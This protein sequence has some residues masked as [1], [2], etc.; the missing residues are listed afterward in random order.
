MGKK[1]ST[2]GPETLNSLVSSAGWKNAG[3]R[4]GVFGG[5][6]G[7]AWFSIV[8][9]EIPG[10]GRYVH[11]TSVGDDCSVYLNGKKLLE[12]ERWIDAFDVPLDSA[13]KEGGPNHLVLLVENTYGPVYVG[14][15]DL[16]TVA[17]RP[18][19]PALAD[20]DDRIWRPLNLPH[21]FVVEGKFN[22]KGNDYNGYLI[23]GVGWYR[24]E[25]E[26]PASDRGRRLWLDFDGAFRNSR[27]WLNGR[28]LGRHNSGYTPFRYDITGLVRYGGRNVLSVRVDARGAEGWWYEGGGLY[29]HVWLTKADPVHVAPWGVYVVSKPVGKGAS[30]VL[31][32][33]LRSTNTNPEPG[34]LRLVNEIKDPKGRLVLRLASPLT[35]GASREKTLIQ[36]GS[37]KRALLWDLDHPHLYRVT[38]R[39]EREGRE[40]DHVE[41]S[42]G[43]RSIRF[44]KD[45]G[46]F[47][48][49]KPV[50]L[51][52][53]CNHQDHAGLG[54][55]LPDRLFPYR[56]EK[57]KA[58]GSNA[59]RCAHHP[60]ASELLDA[61]DRMGMLVVDENRR[62][63]DSAE[64]L[65]QVRTMV[66]RDRNHPSVILWSLCNEEP[67]QG[68]PIGYRRALAMKKTLLRHDRTRPVTAA[69]N[70]SFEGGLRTVVDVEGINYNINQYQDFR[71]KYPGTPLFGSETASTLCSRGIYETDPKKGYVS[72]YDVNHTMWSLPAEAAWRPVAERDYL[73]G[74]FIWTGFDYR[75]EP[76][77]Y[78][79]PCI[80]S[81]FGVLDTCGFPKDNF[82]YYKAWWG[83]EPVLHLF[84][85]WNWK[86][87]EGKEIEVWCHG[88][89]DR[90]ELFLNGNL[91]GTQE[92][93]RLGHIEWKVRYQPGTL[94]ARGWKDG[95]V[96]LE[97]KV[98]T[99][100]K[101]A[102]IILK[103]YGH[104]L[105]ANGQDV[106][107][108]EVS[109][110]DK[111]GRL[112]STADNLIQFRV[113]GPAQI[114]G[115]GNGD[116]SSHEPDKASRRRVF[117]GLCAVFVRAG[118]KPGRIALTAMSRGLK[119]SKVTL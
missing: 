31:E 89:V 88:N 57:L 100:G 76:T 29:R 103:P 3:L 91:L 61:C 85:H 50:K 71:K 5:K 107:P 102:S 44:D 23:P 54:V 68:K 83:K 17:S 14:E 81:H 86:G 78:K 66:L 67:L 70:H 32:T 96:V 13:W 87:K 110:L 36:K 56:I 108:V 75:G 1:K 111:Q 72:A 98:E 28:F 77:P 73:A 119:P 74:A 109:V 7:L 99:T 52:G 49:G 48:N 94:L 113:S 106:I 97:S 58:M 118:E 64:V 84:P 34:K 11:F 41:T 93:P 25:L 37:I 45:K 35:I 6:P 4:Q 2:Y 53:T 82:Y 10:P 40:I 39:I 112:V 46:F 30:I 79:W 80:N 69:V 26:I 21:D 47:L 116:P 19:G 104:K 95:R 63:G 16:E 117:N 27:V 59:Y 105:K 43:I 62:L 15:A 33:T 55:A 114:A 22:P 9:P 60:H 51:K 12:H 115:V 90:V 8:L 101:P 65:E 92:I 24:R 20:F 18:R 38:T 42:F